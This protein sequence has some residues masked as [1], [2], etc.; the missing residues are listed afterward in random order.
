MAS[1]M[2]ISPQCGHLMRSSGSS[3]PHFTHFSATAGLIIPHAG[4]VLGVEAAAGLKHMGLFPFSR[5]KA[6]IPN[7]K[8]FGDSSLRA[9]SGWRQA[10]RRRSPPVLI[11]FPILF[12]ELAKLCGGRV[13]PSSPQARQQA[14]ILWRLPSNAA[15]KPECRPPP[16][17]QHTDRNTR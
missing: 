4:H 11:S 12:R 8:L 3:A 5:A 10:L 9:S 1:L 14:H 17:G 7:D 2:F 6:D 15:G 16:R 13:R